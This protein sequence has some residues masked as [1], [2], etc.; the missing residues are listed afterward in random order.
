MCAIECE[1]HFTNKHFYSLT[2][3]LHALFSTPIST[4]YLSQGKSTKHTLKVGESWHIYSNKRGRG[5]RVRVFLTVT[6]KLIDIILCGEW[7]L[8][9]FDGTVNISWIG[10]DCRI[11]VLFAGFF[12]TYYNIESADWLWNEEFFWKQWRWGWQIMI[13]MIFE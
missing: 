1:C 9:S 6:S 3:W 4:T 5:G 7:K 13:M 8:Y 11:C 10:R 2:T 12:D